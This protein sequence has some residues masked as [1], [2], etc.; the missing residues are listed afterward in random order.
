MNRVDRKLHPLT[1][2]QLRELITEKTNPGTPF[3][4]CPLSVMLERP[5]YGRLEQAIHAT[6]ARHDGVRLRLVEVDFDYRQYVAAYEPRT[7]DFFDFSSDFGRERWDA[8]VKAAAARPFRLDDA[9][10]FYV[11]LVK[12]SPDRGGF[13]IN[14]HHALADGG[15]M[16]ILIDEI[17]AEYR[18]LG[19]LQEQNDRPRPSY[20]E[21]IETERAYLASDQAHADREFWLQRLDGLTE[22]TTLPFARNRKTGIVA[23]YTRADVPDEVAGELFDGCRR[24]GTSFYRLMLSVF[25]GY[26]ARVS[27]Q[28]DVVIGVL[29]HNRSTERE[30]ATVGMYVNAFPLRVR[31]DVKEPFSALLRRI[32]ADVRDILKH[33]G[34]YP[35]DQLAADLRE[36]TGKVP[37]LLNLIVVGQDFSTPDGEI[38]YH[39]P[40]Y[41][42][43]PFHAIFNV[44]TTA[45]GKGSLFF[46]TPR[47]MFER[48][49]VERMV[50]HL[51]AMAAAV[52][53]APDTA[54]ADV[55]LVG[56]AER[57]L[58]METFN[59]T[60][61]DYRTDASVVERFR[62]QAE[63]TPDHP[64]LVFGGQSMTYRE[65]DERSDAVAARLQALG[66]G[67][68]RIVG[69]IA[70]PSLERIV[71]V[72]GAL[73]SGAAYMPVTRA[74]RPS[75]S[76]SCSTTARPWRSSP[77]GR[78]PTRPGSTPGPSCTSTTRRAPPARP[79]R[80][81]RRGP[82]IWP[83]SSTRRDPPASRRA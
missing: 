31:V 18:A 6:L 4:N 42:Q 46:V 79:R 19:G 37:S 22:E 11:A 52:V 38:T 54:P 16:K 3:A 29:T 45:P 27:G 12:L 34:R 77:C 64:A 81:H 2:P 73:K 47:G 9:D 60:R 65:L 26:V 32:D 59:D 56:P 83:T 23:D 66:A 76:A 13:F 10:L 74:T 63:K 82:S 48:E 70:P 68:D 28:E 35:F 49:D 57:R 17:V 39:H 43:P 8:W 25:L 44:V 5:D 80:L 78:S 58:L 51:L 62:E 36:R 1:R 69:I 55:D 21:F 67:P 30:R 53:A 7:L 71:G 40:G 33:H 41:E 15:T 20:L 14:V 75:A 24:L 72:W 50:T 61:A